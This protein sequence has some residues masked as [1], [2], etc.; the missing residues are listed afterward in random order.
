VRIRDILA[1]LLLK[2]GLYNATPDAVTERV[3]VIK[4][5]SVC[6]AIAPESRFIALHYDSYVY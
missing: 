4:S 2:F 3:I 5:Q 6:N 1:K